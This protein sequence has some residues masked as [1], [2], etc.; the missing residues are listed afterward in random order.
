M[1][2]WQRFVKSLNSMYGK[3][4]TRKSTRRKP[5]ARL[6]VEGLEDRLVPTG[7]ANPFTPGN[8]AVVLVNTPTGSLADSGSAVFIDEYTPSG[9]LVQ[10]IA[11]P[12]TSTVG[13][14][15]SL[16]LGNSTNE[17]ELNLST[18]GKD[19]LLTGYDTTVGGA[20]GGATIENSTSASINRTI[21]EINASGSINTTTALT[22]FAS[23]GDPRGVV[24][25]DATG[26]WL[27]GQDG[28]SG[29]VRYISALGSSTTTSTNL[30]GTVDKNARDVEIWNG[31]L[32]FGQDKV[33]TAPIIEALNT[34][35][36][37]GL[38]E[39]TAAFN[40]GTGP[41]VIT[42]LPGT[43]TTNLSTPG[44]NAKTTGFV[45]AKLGASADFTINGVDSGYNT[46]YVADEDTHAT[47]SNP[48]VTKYSWTGSSW[49]SNG[50]IGSSSLSFEG[51]IGSVSGT[52]VT[53]YATV[54]NPT[55]GTDGIVSI[56][57]NSGFNS[58][59]TN[60]GSSTPT[61]IVTAAPSGT[62]FRGIAFTPDDGA[63]SIG[64]L[65]GTTTAYNTGGAAVVGPSASF[66]DT[67]NFMGGSLTALL[68]GAGA[69][70]SDSL[71]I[72]TGNSITFTGTTFGNVLYSGNLIGTYT[73]TAGAA[74][75]L[76]VTFNATGAETVGNSSANPVSSAAVQALIQQVTF[77]TTGAS[78]TSN[79][80]VTFTLKKNSAADIAGAYGTLGTPASD[81]TTAT[82]TITV[83][84]SALSLTAN[85]GMTVAQSATAT[86][87]SSELAYADTS[88]TPANETYKVTTAPTVGTLYRNGLALT[89][90]SSFSQ[91]D[92]NNNLITYTQNGSDTT[93][94]S[95]AFTVSDPLSF[96][97]SG[98][99]GITITAPVLVHDSAVLV[100]AGSSVAIGTSNLDT[101]E[102]GATAGQLTYTIGTGPSSGTLTNTNT[103][104]T[105]S[106]GSQFTQ[107]DVN[108]GYITYTNT[109]TASETD[110]FTF[111]V[112]D[113]GT[114]STGSRTFSIN[115]NHA[116]AV[117]VNA[118]LSINPGQQ[119]TITSS[120]LS[121]TD[122]EQ[123]PSSLTY[124]I[125]TVPTSGTLAR[126]GSAMTAGSMFTQADINAGNISY[127][128]TGT[129]PASDS[130]TFTVSD[131]AG[132]TLASTSFALNV[133]ALSS[134]SYTA[135]NSIYSQGFDT[136]DG[137]ATSSVGS[138]ALGA[139]T[140][141]VDL[142]AAIGSYAAA[143][144]M[145]GW[146]VDLTGGTSA[147]KFAVQTNAQG[148]PS[149]TSGAFYSYGS[150]NSPSNRALG[151]VATNSSTYTMGVELINNTS[152]PLDYLTLS[153]TGEEWQDGTAAISKALDFGYLVQATPGALPTSG[154]TADSALTFTSPISTGVGTA[155]D[156]TLGANQQ[157]F[158]NVPIS[159][160][161]PWGV[162]EAL[163]LTWQSSSGAGQGPG[164]AIDNFQFS[165][166]ATPAVA[167]NTGLTTQVSQ[168]VFITSAMLSTS[169]ADN[170]ASQLTYTVTSLPTNGT[171][172]INN[173]AQT[174][175]GGTFTQAQL[176]TG[177]YVKFTAGSAQA[178][179]S[180]GFTVADPAG[181][182]ASGSFNIGIGD[183][184]PVLATNAGLTLVQGSTATITTSDLKVTDTD[185]TDSQLM[186]TIGTAPSHGTLMNTNT[187]AALSAGD[188][189]TEQDL[190]DGYIS[191]VNDNS[192]NGSD[193]FTFTVSDGAG[194]SIGTT[195][196][197]IT[198]DLLPVLANNTGLN[199]PAGGT[200]FIT[201]AMLDATGTGTAS[202]IQYALTSVP[203][204]GN[205]YNTAVS[206][207]TALT[208][209][210]TFYQN[211][212][213]G[214]S[215]IEYVSN[216]SATPGSSDSFSFT[217]TD[218]SYATQPGVSGTF[219]IAVNP[220]GSSAAYGGGAY[221][222]SFAGLPSS[223]TL[224]FAQS[225]PFDLDGSSASANSPQGAGATGMT[226]WSMAQIGGT[227]ANE[228]K[229]FADSGGTST[230]G[231]H[232]YSGS[233][234]PSAG[235][236][237]LGLVSTGAD[238][239]AIGLT[240][241]NNTSATLT[242]FTLSYD[243]EEWRIG[244]DNALVFG[245]KVGG[246][247]VADTG[248]TTVSAL[249]YDGTTGTAAANPS[250]TDTG[251]SSTVTGLSWA[252]GQT[253]VIRWTQASGTSGGEGLGITNVNFSARAT[254]VIDENAGLTIDQGHTSTITSSVLDVTESG[255]AD[256]QVVYTLGT[257]PAHGTLYDNESALSAGDMFTQA[258]I[259]NG[260]LTYGND[261]SAS[262]SD[263]FQFTVSDGN[264]GSIP[265]TS[266]SI[267]VNSSSSPNVLIDEIEVNPPGSSDNRYEY[268]EL[269]GTP[270][271][272]L[273]NVY[274]VTFDGIH[275]SNP[276]TADLVVNLNGDSI[277]SDGLL[278]IQNS[279][280]AGHAIPSGTTVVTDPTFFTQAGGF[281]NGTLSFYLY[282]SSNAFIQGTDYDT[283]N[284]GTLDHLPSGYEILDH[285]AILDNNS[286]G[287]G[288]IAYGNVVV[289]EA[290]NTGTPDAITRIPGNTS[291]SSAAWYGGELVDTG[292]VASQIE[293]DATRASANEP[294]GA[295]LTPGAANVIPTTI[296]WSNPADI[297]YGTAL[298]SGQLD[299][300]AWS[301]GSSIPGNFSYT[302]ANGTTPAS[303]AVLN[304]GQDQILNV[305]FTP[306]GPDAAD[307]STAS[308]Q[309]QINV[310]PEALTITAG[311]QTQDY[312][313]VS[314]GSSAY[315]VT[316]GALQNGDT[317]SGVTLTAVDIN[318][319]GTSGSFNDNVGTW[320]ID[321]SAAT[322]TGGFNNTNYDISYASGTLTI[323]PLALTVSGISGTGRGYDGTTSDA[324]SGTASL[325]GNVV[326]GDNVFLN[327]PGVGTLA[328]ANAGS[329][330]VTIS[331]YS[332]GGADSGDYSF[333]QP[334]VGNV[335]ISPEAITITASDQTQTYGS[336]SLGSSA[337]SVTTGAVQTGDSIS[338]VTL[339][340]VD[341]NSLGQSGSGNDNAGTWGISASAATG[342]G[343][344][345]A[346]NYDISYAG[347]TLTIDPLALTVTGISGTGRG[348]D[349]T[350]SD[351]LAGTPALSSNY[352]S[353]DNAFL[354]GTGVGTLASANAGSEAVTISGYSLG[355][356]DSGDYSFSQPTVDNVTI[357]PEAITIK[358]GDQ[359]QTYGSVSLGS[360]AF[361]V[362]TGAVQTG[363]SISGVTLSAVD[364]NS[365]G[366]SGSGNDNA[367]T[368]G[369]SASAATGTGGFNTTNYDISYAGGTLTIDPLALTVTGISGTGR[370]Y[371]GT[372]SDA[373]AGT[374][375]LLGKISGDNV[376]LTGT[377][378]GT[379]AS[380]NAG[381]EAVTVSGYGINGGDAGDYSFSQPT[382]AN[383]TISPEAITIKA[384]DQTQNYGSISLGSSAYSVTIGAVQTGDSISGVTLTAADINSLGTSGSGNDNAGTWGINASAAT[385]TGGFNTTNYSISY[386]PGT[387]TISPLALTVSGIAGTNRTYDGTTSDALT[388]TPSLSSNYISGD[389]VTLTGTGVG[390]LAS[391][392]AGSEPVTITGY[393]INGGDAGDYSFSQPTVASVTIGKATP[394]ITWSNPADIKPGTALS[395]TQLDATANVAGSS[396]VYTPGLGA[397]LSP[398]LG[399]T[400]SVLF[401]PLDTT[402]YNTATD[403]VSI[404]VTAVSITSSIAN[405]SASATTLS[406]SGYGFSTT[407]SSNTV[408]LSGGATATVTAATATKLTLSVHNLTAGPLT[409]TVHNTA[410][411]SE[412]AQVATVTPVVTTAATSVLANAT[413]LLIK[414]FGFDSTT[415]GNNLVSF[416][417]GVTG[418][419]TSA[420]ATQLT[421]T[422]LT[423]L[424]AG[425][426]TA[427]LTSD[428]IASGTAVQVAKVSPVVTPSS[429]PLTAGST[430][431]S[432]TINGYGFTTG[433]TVTLTGGTAGTVTVVSPNQLTVAVTGL[434][435]GRLNAVVTSSAVSSGTAVQ[436]AT[437]SP[438]ITSSI[439]NLAANATTLTINGFGFSTTAANNVVTLAN[440]SGGV[441]ATVTAATAT[442]LTVSLGGN[443]PT[444]GALSASVTSNGQGSGTAVQVATVI[445]VV[446][447]STASLLANATTM[448][449]AGF[450][451]DTATPGNNVVTFSGGATGTVTSA[452]STQLTVTGLTGLPAGTLTA[453]V[454]TDGA[455]STAAVQVA[456]VSPVVVS[457]TTTLAAN[458]AS[459][460][461]NGFGFTAGTTVK[462]TG[463]TAGATTVLSQNQLKVNVTNL[464]AG[465]LTAVVASSA[466]SSGTAV[467]VA[468]V[469]PVI[470]PS[471]ASLAA[472]ATMLTINGF[473]FSTT[474]TNDVVTLT[475]ANG[476][477]VSETATTATGTKLTVKLTGPLP[478]G[479]LLATVTINGLYSS[480][481]QEVAYV[482]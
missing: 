335:T 131:G 298:G 221:T 126:S 183:T 229:F 388:G 348:Y 449:I 182:S 265:S 124:T 328:S 479:A 382:V 29:A 44:S 10:Q 458:V 422:G 296:D 74:S 8:I 197:A 196:F 410:G 432:L 409:A 288:D 208:V 128:S 254:P 66:S 405:L 332:L 99:F 415:P 309:V 302:L 235:E 367:G 336:V 12:T 168:T 7:S 304:A 463:G 84:S 176:A 292:N 150:T 361:S 355:G 341:T 77:S 199:T 166:D 368:W 400:L 407:P 285:V 125:G 162:G 230:G 450:G 481:T 115:I 425:T 102:A 89:T 34:S 47:G 372:T 56:T 252:P 301:A 218:T 137:S 443:K 412:T 21:A 482:L 303:G 264:Q 283:N 271:E 417:G 404:N 343:G 120:L 297:T 180:F 224:T 445:P 477:T 469:I 395:S 253:L 270:G 59:I 299:A 104:A 383:V 256:S 267:T 164:L 470:I 103:S 461:I 123:G 195:A 294:A 17:G 437:V 114:G 142:S 406:I 408:T 135:D 225:G 321:A 262:S 306:T 440:L 478:P 442:R 94:D 129:T 282:S 158:S 273:T 398:G 358:A 155:L 431:S 429:G 25:S 22:D 82:Q 157:S 237:A 460:I 236:Q 108:N 171:L 163:W 46:L 23:G 35:S 436:V 413:S 192:A 384:N 345:N 51:L 323:D 274:I 353:G 207:T 216:P 151:I 79:R 286:A 261:G 247:S 68:G 234:A 396:V 186:F 24:G 139:N 62:A 338:G 291:I 278:V 119:A 223:G 64:G 233:A 401:T 140:T 394:I 152:N 31:Q 41:T 111:T 334:T 307:Y 95:F 357:S 53:L 248:F 42:P 48:G 419:V 305:T 222:Q 193:S 1:F 175:T 43:G 364:T 272:A 363:D 191:Y 83:Q 326:T 466:V 424:L 314:L 159:L 105:L 244:A 3:S 203:T 295:V 329:E 427:S 107:A 112:T 369:I 275:T 30:T 258:D 465:P 205:L 416:S 201:K 260:L 356:A 6:G 70:S 239:S 318:S 379:L 106:A 88:T 92:I 178:S 73:L 153:Y 147:Q 2:G 109:N 40:A 181:A 346:T 213:S 473:G 441:T 20:G 281:A 471:S 78:G 447:L 15:Q 5:K 452:T 132:G 206:S 365:L 143:S 444:G 277:G 154:L 475:F 226:G 389:N 55:T 467:Q 165:A 462:L 19:L 28:T 320:G 4:S 287:S 96:S 231:V 263:A 330:A 455:S 185:N 116:P 91:A 352:I 9:T 210:S 290:N 319:L 391:A 209:G 134:V 149:V 238:Q 26:F 312:G 110:S 377:G 101:T 160:A 14:N 220:A 333:T 27:A 13:G 402:D 69:T 347:G 65:G 87:T 474:S 453:T 144:G 121:V 454:K 246:A 45:F 433:S 184:P 359:T 430:A 375:S 366:Q 344:F 100:Q 202:Q 63:Q 371:D 464:T 370:N 451:F 378:V 58:A 227:T 439:A 360:S 448:T 138:F 289:T 293:Y 97:A 49:V 392:S 476:T 76:T 113:G 426:L 349:G 434:T 322:G 310:D 386:A 36:T 60:N 217:V 177:T 308:A 313:S 472:T 418:T 249:G 269:A 380:A 130:F 242:Q 187:D 16:V 228:E 250:V 324:L 373:L 67:S 86:I 189:F 317:I 18:D 38:Q 71:G 33:A 428:G 232:A 32:Y 145:P 446:T 399:Q 50:T 85:T 81:T 122:P 300:S 174:A 167:T 170:T 214:T 459:L 339:S 385:G 188:T 156:G 279:A 457:S 480:L 435:A 161:T 52:T 141:P 468:T 255:L 376:F 390:T 284:D 414:G 362:T 204:G 241:V 354:S 438:A 387:L 251:V 342:T 381:S 340:A 136:L 75:T 117:A 351:A 403:S 276:G 93:S 148:G 61:T 179:S 98:T 327:G 194:G 393:G 80:T 57:D 90:N 316:S 374:P 212:I 325:S 280:S 39:P 219:D 337:Y 240:L 268:V 200:T 266:F 133:V 411:T 423:G 456:K 311:D 243:G 421:V 127:L 118:G 169:D 397:V 37:T 315:G 198:V 146:Y 331:G 420:T 245:Y 257:A 259:D 11:L 54:V 172:Y 72:A 190:D 350:A 173:V 215:T 211:A